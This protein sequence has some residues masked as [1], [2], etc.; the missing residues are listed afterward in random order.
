[1]DF[2]FFSWPMLVLALFVFGFAPGLMLR[3]IVLAYS[4]DDPRRHELRGELYHVPRFER[5]FWVME[6]LELALVEGLGQRI[7]WVATGQ[8]IDRWHLGSGVR[9]HREHADTFWIPSEEERGAVLPGMEV[10][11]AFD[12]RDGWSE[13][14]W[15]TVIGRKGR[16]LIGRLENDP[17]VI[18]RLLWGD[19]IK[20]KSDHI[21]DIWYAHEGDA[22]IC[23]GRGTPG[24]PDPLVTLQASNGHDKYHRVASDRIFGHLLKGAD[25]GV[26]HEASRDHATCY[27]LGADGLRQL[28]EPP[29]SLPPSPC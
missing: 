6:Q 23:P 29:T 16:K 15:V 20:F 1:M 17:T 5:P 4:R 10:K 25:V 26:S 3:L 11:L 21:I 24:H 19:T 7:M 14:M 27:E 9:Y 8:V 18:P 13:R 2:T 22:E 12:T 28:P